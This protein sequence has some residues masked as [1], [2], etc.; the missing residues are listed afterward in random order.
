[1]WAAKRRYLLDEEW[2]ELYDLNSKYGKWGPE[3][4][5]HEFAALSGLRHFF[6]TGIKSFH[7]GELNE[8][9]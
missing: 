9:G 5:E 6:L 8:D 4:T 7:P 3:Q 1:M 2:Y